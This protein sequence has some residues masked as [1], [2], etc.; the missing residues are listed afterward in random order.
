MEIPHTELSHLKRTMFHALHVLNG[1]ASITGLNGLHATITLHPRSREQ[2][3]ALIRIVDACTFVKVYQMNHRIGPTT[4]ATRIAV[5][6]RSN[7]GQ[8]YNEICVFW[9]SGTTDASRS[10]EVA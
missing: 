6:P 9:P 7:P 3:S 8:A 1:G 10:V 2:F 5:M 4:W